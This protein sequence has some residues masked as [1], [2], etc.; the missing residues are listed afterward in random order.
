MPAVLGVRPGENSAMGG[1]GRLVGG[2]NKLQGPFGDD[3][4]AEKGKPQAWVIKLRH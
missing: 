2:A 1:A 4:I 3:D